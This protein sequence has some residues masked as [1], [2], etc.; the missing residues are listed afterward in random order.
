MKLEA[1]EG[2]AL[3]APLS[4]FCAQTVG[5]RVVQSPLADGKTNYHPIP[6]GT[7]VWGAVIRELEGK[8]ALQH[9]PGPLS[10]AVIR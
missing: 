8:S 7:S 2:P 5:C 6:G 10:A 1:A 9:T 3:P 4:L